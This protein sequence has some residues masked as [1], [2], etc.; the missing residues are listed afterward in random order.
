MALRRVRPCY[1]TYCLFFNLPPQERMLGITMNITILTKAFLQYYIEHPP[2]T[3][4]GWD[5]APPAI[6]NLVRLIDNSSGSI[7]TPGWSYLHLC[8][9]SSISLRLTSACPTTSLSSHVLWL[10][11]FLVLLSTFSWLESLWWC[12]G[13]GDGK[14]WVGFFP[15]SIWY[16][17]DEILSD[18]FDWIN[19]FQGLEC[20]VAE[21]D[22]AFE[23]I[24][25][26]YFLVILTIA[27]EAGTARAQ[28]LP[29]R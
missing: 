3:Q 19:I 27:I 6:V 1:F 5:F 28:N 15:K 29:G 23:I 2:D 13:M 14:Q 4:C 20:V 22:L 16:Y 8:L 11:S 12:D 26:I 17:F 25:S 7:L 9:G 24:L 21:K 18:G 10:L